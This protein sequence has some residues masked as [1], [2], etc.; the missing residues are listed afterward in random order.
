LVLAL[1]AALLGNPAAQARPLYTTITI[2]PNATDGVDARIIAA[3]YATSNFGADSIGVGNGLDGGVTER[4]LLKFD[5]SGIPA[6]SVI[7]SATLSLYVTT[8]ASSNARTF[9]VYKVKRIW[10]EN[11]VTWN[12]YSTGN[13]W[14]TAGGGG[15][16][17]IDTSF[18]GSRAFS[19]SETL[20]VF[21]S[22]SLDAAAVQ[23]MIPGGAWTNNGFMVAADTESA[24]AYSFSS[25]D[26]GNSAQWPKL[27]IDYTAPTAT[28]TMT[29]T[30]SNT[31]TASDTPTITPTPSNT[32]TASN[33]PV[34]TNTPTSTPTVTDTPVPATA[35]PTFTPS[36]TI[37][38]TP[39][40]WIV[41]TL[42]APVLG[43]TVLIE[44]RW[45]FGE[46]AIF[47]AL[48][49]LGAL[50]GLRWI[51]DWVRAEMVKPV[52]PRAD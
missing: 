24:D 12:A 35:T 27:V 15:A 1:A 10:V 51:F 38:P 19:A 14:Q 8:D 46:E 36:P 41:I 20:N 3:P 33:T 23:S 43:T 37:T 26:D 52:D 40:W 42:P 44:R 7:N 18:I 48:V 50:L 31:P 29:F 5:L 45:T 39:P 21:V 16:N 25:S 49:A 28:P 34:D 4:G 22:W 11:Q 32:P 30:P 9:R 17:D 2:Q 47:F 6:G 13:N